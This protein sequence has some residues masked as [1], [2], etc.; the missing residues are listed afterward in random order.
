MTRDQIAEQYGEELL[1]LDPPYFDGAIIGVVHQF[2]HPTVC[3]DTNKVINILM[4][5]DGMTED[6]A[7]EYFDYNILGAWTGEHTPSFLESL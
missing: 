5:H 4:E 2:M 7:Y 6:E 3:Y 1:F